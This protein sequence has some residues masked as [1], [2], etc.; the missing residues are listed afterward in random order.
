[1]TSSNF[2]EWQSG[3][4]SHREALRRLLS[5]LGEVESQIAP[6]EAEKA[7]LRTQISEVLAEMGGRAESEG[8]RLTITSPGVSARYDAKELD[9]LVDYL[10]A[11][12]D[13]EIARLILKSRKESARAGQLRIVPPGGGRKAS[14]DVAP[15]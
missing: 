6:L 2:T 4:I 7:E 9:Q 15:L 13:D 8:Y 14:D 1:M 10:L 3:A 12:G 11:R 5:D